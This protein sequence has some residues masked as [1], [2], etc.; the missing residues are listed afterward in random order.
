MI[1]NNYPRLYRSGI[2]LSFPL[3]LSGFKFELW[4]HNKSYQERK[5]YAE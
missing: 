3:P 1:I 4:E 5:R 2:F